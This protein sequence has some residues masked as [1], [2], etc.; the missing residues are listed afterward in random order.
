M[1]T[2]RTRGF[3]TESGPAK[4]KVD[5]VK[6]IV[7]DDRA[8]DSLVLKPGCKELILSF[9]QSQNNSETLMD[10]VIEG[11]GVYISAVHMLCMFMLTSLQAKAS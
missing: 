9:T 8:F 2:H 1:H 6:E 7:W 10:D 5:G 3:D 4:F 11:K